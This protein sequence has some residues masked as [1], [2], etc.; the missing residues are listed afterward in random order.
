[1]K[2][3]PFGA[4]GEAELAG[5]ILKVAR[6]RKLEESGIV[7]LSRLPYSVR[8]LLENVLRRVGEDPQSIDSVVPVDFVVDHSVQVDYWGAE[9]AL[10]RNMALEIERNS[11]R[12]KLIRWA[13]NEFRNLRVIPMRT[14]IVHQINVEHLAS[15][16]Q[17]RGRGEE[18]DWAFP[19]T[20][21][22]TDSHTPMVNGI[23]VL[24]W[25]V[26]G[27]E[28]EAVMLGQP[29]FM[30]LPEVVGVRLSGSLPAGATT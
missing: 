4:W 10:E 19:D 24:G 9:G 1:M 12:Y 30:L 15:V 22:G 11:E 5:D 2:A 17:R 27:I 26:G 29:I 7:E 13:Q 21:V 28:A 23:G 6:L 16:V 18:G 20:V 3:D 8:V 25:G 14:G